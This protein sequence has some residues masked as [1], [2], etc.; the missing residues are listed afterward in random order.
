MFLLLQLQV[1]ISLFLDNLSVTPGNTYFAFVSTNF[2]SN[3]TSDAAGTYSG[4]AAWLANT[5]YPNDLWM[6]VY[7]F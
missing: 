5:A 6:D 3:W 7:G 1:R 4:G 2:L